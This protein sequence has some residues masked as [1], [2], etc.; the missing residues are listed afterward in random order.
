MSHHE[1]DNEDHIDAWHEGYSAHHKAA[2]PYSDERL[3]GHWIE[4][5]KQR[6][7]DR[8]RIAPAMPER[9][10]GYYHTK[11]EML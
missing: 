5:Q 1:E 7:K 9:P 8:K 4:G 2:C 3:V 6:Q 10:E 11:P